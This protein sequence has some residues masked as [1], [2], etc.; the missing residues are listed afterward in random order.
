MVAAKPLPSV[1]YLH[2]C[3]LI[4]ED[5]GLVW[6]HRPACHF[7]DS[8]AANWWV[9]K[10]SGKPAFTSRSRGYFCGTLDRTPYL[11]HR[12]IWKMLHGDEPPMIDHI[13]GDGFN[14]TPTNLRATDSAGNA[15]NSRK[16]PNTTSRF[17]GVSWSKA[18]NK[19]QAQIRTDGHVKYL[20]CFTDEEQ[21]HAAYRRAAAE[22]HGLFANYGEC[23]ASKR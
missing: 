2:E 11:A 19:W 12:V 10:Y 18:A 14:N 9:S 3:L 8:H 15:R 20:G 16:Q 21:A 23:T 4:Q 6:R 1:G 5:G 13:N 17:K 22:F 7:V